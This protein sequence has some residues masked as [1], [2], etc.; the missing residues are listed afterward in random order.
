MSERRLR[1]KCRTLLRELEMQPPFDVGELCARL[2]KQRERPIRLQAYPIPAPG[3]FGLWLG[4]DDEDVIVYQEETSR[5]HQVHIILHE[6]GHMI[7]GHASDEQD[8]D[9]PGL[10]PDVDPDVVRR[11][12][13]RTDYHS[14]EEIEAEKIATIILEWAWELDARVPELPRTEAGRRLRGG[15]SDHV[16]WM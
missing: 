3:P 13:R 6:I 7:A 9:V 11:W 4:A 16:G 2:A 8:E 5:L 15:L 1:A 14:P 12:L 10:F